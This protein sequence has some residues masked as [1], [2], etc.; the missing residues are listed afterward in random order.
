MSVNY[1]PEL[2]PEERKLGYAKYYDIPMTPMG[3]R[4][5]Q[6]LSYGPIDPEKAIKPERWLDLLKP[7][8]YTLPEY[9]YCVMPD[10]TGYLAIYTYYP[11]SCT[12]QM[13]KWYFH[14]VNM[15]SKG[16]PRDK[17][18]LRYKIWNPA[19]HYSHGYVNGK[20]RTDGIYTIES[21][22]LGEGEDKTYCI[23]NNVNLREMGLTEERE[24]ELKA[25]GCFVDSAVESFHTMGPEHRRLGGS[26]LCL[27]LSRPCPQGGMEKCTREWIGYGIV[28]GKVT[29]DYTTPDYMLCEDYLRKAIIHSTTEAQHLAKFLP[30]LYAEYHDLPDD[31]D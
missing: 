2:S 12:P 18:N 23:R 10:G 17:G 26:H 27:T 31:A 24:N 16:M 13:L 6:L 1:K 29:R 15:Y 7:E 3:I 5:Q 11:N 19:D 30:D 21:L 28:D 14:W 25:A 4:E 9:G 20:D 8:G 22:D